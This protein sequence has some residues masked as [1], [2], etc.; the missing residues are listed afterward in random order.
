MQL[1]MDMMIKD[2]EFTTNHPTNYPTSFGL[3]LKPIKIYYPRTETESQT[4]PSNQI[5]LNENKIG[6][7]NENDENP[8]KLQQNLQQSSNKISNKAPTKSPTKLQQNC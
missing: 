6:N 8:T 7:K 5:I 4:D 2:A 1:A 3:S